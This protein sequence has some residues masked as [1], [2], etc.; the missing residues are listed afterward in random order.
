MPAKRMDRDEFFV[1]LSPM[2]EAG[3]AKVLWN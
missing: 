2:G 1:K 3:L